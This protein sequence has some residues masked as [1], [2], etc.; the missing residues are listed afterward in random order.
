M[1]SNDKDDEVPVDALIPI[2][3]LARRAEIPVKTLRHYSDIGIVPPAHRTE[4]GYRLYGEEQRLRLET[5]KTLRSLGFELDEISW[6][7]DGGTR[8][9]GLRRQL[10][11]VRGR[12][13]ELRRLALILQAAIERD[14]PASV[15]LARL[16]TI[17]RV[18]E[19]QRAA[20]ID[21]TADDHAATPGAGGQTL[22]E[23]PDSADHGQVDAWLELAAL[24]ADN[25]G[26]VRADVADRPG[27]EDGPGG[28]ATD[29]LGVLHDAMEARSAGVAPDDARADAV[30]DRLRSAFGG[31]LLRRFVNEVAWHE[32][33]L[34][35]RRYWRLVARVRG[36]PEHSPQGQAVDWLL[37]ALRLRCG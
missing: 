15:H 3:E 9:S 18:A 26:P 25:A 24:L 27:A 36:W 33:D 21:R 19:D 4:A 5:V 11:G 1:A 12:L 23:L 32:G 29:L 10:C 7:V 28:L 17:A 2:G 31:D 30:V 37:A 22:P 13:L 34:A 14:E 8:R 35:S 20:L 6:M 16:Q